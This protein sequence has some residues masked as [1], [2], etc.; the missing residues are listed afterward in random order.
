MADTPSQ[1]KS[2][3]EQLRELRAIVDTLASSLTTV[4]GNQSQLNV[5]VNR[6]QSG[7][8]QVDGSTSTSAGRDP[9]ATAARHGHKLLFLTYDGTDDPF[10]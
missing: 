5:A 7:K 1:P 6:L 2:I 8:L 9:L 10:P 3:E 4:K